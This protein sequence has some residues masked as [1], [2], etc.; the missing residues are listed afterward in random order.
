MKFLSFKSFNRK[1]I[2]T[3]ILTLFTLIILSAFMLNKQNNPIIGTWIDIH[4]TNTSNGRWV[5]T[6]NKFKEY[7]E[8]NLEEEDTYKLTKTP[9]PCG[10]DMSKR[11][12]M[13][14]KNRILILTNTKTGKKRC[15]LV[16]KLTN[17]R[18]ILAAL[19]RAHIEVDTLKKVQQ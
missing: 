18:L 10:I 9:H 5:F 1:Y 7:Y 12:Q 16:Y 2:F 6:S 15:S 3:S 19:T 4:S 8:G 14:P 11:L 13:Y 17:K